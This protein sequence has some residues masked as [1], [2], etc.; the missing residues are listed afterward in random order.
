MTERNNLTSP[1][2]KKSTPTKK[3]RRSAKKPPRIPSLPMDEWIAEVRAASIKSNLEYRKHHEQYKPAG[4]PGYP[5]RAYKDFPGWPV[6]C[7]TNNQFGYQAERAKGFLP[8]HEAVLKAHSF[9]LPTHEAW[10]SYVQ[11]CGENWDET[12]PKRPDIFY[13]KE[14]NGWGDWLGNSVDTRLS[15]NQKVIEKN[16]AVLYVY[17]PTHFSFP[18]NLYRFDTEL[19]GISVVRN[20][21]M[22]HGHHLVQAYWYDHTKNDIIQRIINSMSTEWNMGTSKDRLVFNIHDV[23][24]ELSNLMDPVR[25]M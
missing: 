15:A 18:E 5:H 23:C 11:E 8:Y 1:A 14:W 22:E 19:G 4:W 21:I 9:K 6:V 12:I 10:L 20:N 24:W 2:T 25:I 16:L 13:K 17:H 3:P 7:Q